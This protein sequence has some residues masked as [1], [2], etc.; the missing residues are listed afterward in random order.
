M[1]HQLI[2]KHIIIIFSSK[3][4]W[5]WFR[6][7]GIPMADI[8]FIWARNSNTIWLWHL[9]FGQF[10]ISFYFIHLLFTFMCRLLAKS[11][12]NERKQHNS[13]EKYARIY[14]VHTYYQQRIIFM[15]YIS[16]GWNV[17]AIRRYT[18]Q[19]KHTRFGFPFVAFFPFHFY[20]QR[21][22]GPFVYKYI[23]PYINGI[24]NRQ[25]LW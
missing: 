1:C 15:T 19:P 21:Q 11:L 3:C 20:R 7:I 23:H 2:Q 25:W 17:H 16:F 10:R 12:R 22:R 6:R 24:Q 8:L 14:Y 18:A 4:L 13:L 9:V 5:Q